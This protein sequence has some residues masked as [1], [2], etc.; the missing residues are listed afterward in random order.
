[1]IVYIVFYRIDYEGIYDPSLKL[2][3]KEEDA[4]EYMAEIKEKYSGGGRCEII[5]RAVAQ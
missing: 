5:E 4:L 3:A 1:M 2:F